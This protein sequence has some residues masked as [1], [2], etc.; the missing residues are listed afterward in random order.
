MRVSTR[1]TGIVAA[2]MITGLV[3]ASTIAHAVAQ[4]TTLYVDNASACSDTGDGGTDLPFC[5]IQAAANVVLPGQTVVVRVNGSQYY[6]ETLTL[7]R[8]GTTD[9]PIVFTTN[10]TKRGVYPMLRPASGTGPILTL[11]AIHD[12]TVRGLAVQP[13]SSNRVAALVHN[14]QH[15]ALDAMG[16]IGGTANQVR[17]D[18]GSSDVTVTRNDFQLMAAT[19]TGLWVQPGAQRVTVAA[20]RFD[21]GTAGGVKVTGGVTVSVTNNTLTGQCGTAIRVE[22]RSTGVTVAN[23]VVGSRTDN[24][25]CTAT[26][27]MLSVAADSTAETHADYNSIYATAPWYRYDWGGMP[28][29]GAAAFAQNSGQGGHDFD[30]AQ[31]PSTTGPIEDSPLLDSADSGAPG[32]PGSDYNGEPYVDDPFAADT[33][34]GTGHV[35][36]GAFEFQDPMTLTQTTSPATGGQVAPMNASVTVGSASSS[37]WN[38]SM[39]YTVDFGSGDGQPV[40]PG[41]TVTHT[42]ANPGL[43]IETVTVRDTGGSRRSMTHQFVV[44]TTDGPASTLTVG[45]QTLTL[46]NGRTAYDPRAVTVAASV[47]PGDVWQVASGQVLFGDGNTARCTTKCST[48]HAYGRAGTYTVTYRVTDL[49]GR[50][51]TT[52]RSITV[53]DGLVRAPVDPVRLYDSRVNGLIRQVPAHGVV[54]LDVSSPQG[55][56][57]ADAAVLNVTVTNPAKSGF[58]TVYPAGTTRPATSTVNFPAGRTVANQVTAKLNGREVSFY[59]GSAGA[60]DLVVDRFSALTEAGSTYQPLDPLRILDTRS[61]LGG[62]TGPIPGYGAATIQ[63]AGQFGVPADASAVLVNVTATDTRSSGYLTAF[64][65]Y[66][67]GGGAV[68]NTNWYAGQTV[69]NLALVPMGDGRLGITNGSRGT[70]NFVVDLVGWYRPDTRSVYMPTDPARMLDTRTGTGTGG[71]VA[72]LGAHQSLTLQVTGVG[73]VPASGATAAGLNLTVTNATAAGYLTAY[74]AGTTRGTTSSLNYTAGAT[75]A[76]A[77][78]TPVGTTGAVTIYNGGS[79]PVDV[80]AD[81]SGYYF[82][83]PTS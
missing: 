73:P 38:E 34:S 62:T 45:H 54:T 37:A 63:V 82:T 8:S 49:L 1:V 16:F 35:D 11:S 56:P 9:A 2:T 43:Y 40:A 69:A 70:A 32:V 12:V 75:V 71:H 13:D 61:G 67:S 7:T 79:A 5:H 72:K 23:N 30:L 3:T 21:G 46:A 41:G 76:N 57:S 19:D 50:V 52:Q 39:S 20:N 24:T 29:G 59:N 47:V 26:V 83:F 80:I 78:V 31:A 66:V 6:A 42:Y 4:P 68:S 15:V 25:S 74:P 64:G 65:W 27:P 17:V 18:G 36:R 44:G 81:L 48:T 10:S 28:I 60:I 22:Y 51:T 33:G 77:T 58:V 53:G 14:S 55:S